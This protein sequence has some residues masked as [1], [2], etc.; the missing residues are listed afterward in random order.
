[1]AQI[2]VKYDPTLK[3]EEIVE[4]MYAT[5]ENECAEDRPAEVQQTK[6]TGILSPLIKVNRILILWDK[7]TKFELSSKGFLPTLSFTFKDDLGFTKSL[8]QPGNDN[9]VL[10]QILPPFE[11]AYKKIN[12]RFFIN[13]VRIKG[14]IISITASYNVPALVQD[15]LQSFGKITTYDYLDK[16]AKE[17]E[18]GLASNLDGTE[19]ERYIYLRNTNFVK[20]IETEIKRSGNENCILDT[21]IDLHNYVVLCDMLERYNAIESEIKVWTAPTVIPDTENSGEPVQPK[22]E[23]AILSNAIAMRTTQLF[24]NDYTVKNNAGS[25]LRFGTDKVLQS[26][27]IDKSEASSVLI[28]DGDVKKDTFIKTIYKGELF[29]EYDYFTSEFCRSAFLQ[30]INSNIIEVSLSTPLLGLERGGKVNVQ[31]YEVNEIAT[32]IKNE[33]PIETNVPD[34]EGEQTGKDEMT[35]NKQVSGQ[36]FIIGTT[37]KFLGW[38]QGWKYI[39]TLTRP[40]DQVNTYLKDDE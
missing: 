2:T 18:L 8:D 15:K 19:D 32:V 20:S 29:G 5:S 1:M 12:L 24:I 3:I 6:I 11:D 16:I 37:I 21:W 9:L 34:T 13:D 10:L 27:Y 17:C 30:K 25:N 28:Q 36:Y 14:D 40:T 7:V 23:D 31:W 33:N 22:E 4:P 26:Y 38:D 39:L 35:L